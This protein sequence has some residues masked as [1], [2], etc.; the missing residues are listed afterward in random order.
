V[1]PYHFGLKVG[2]S[3]DELRQVLQQLREAGVPIVGMSDHGVSHSVY[4]EDSDGNEVE[5]LA[6]PRQHKL[7]RL[8]SGYTLEI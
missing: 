5:R 8:A 3:D 7:D 1:S 2:E 4:T 6:V